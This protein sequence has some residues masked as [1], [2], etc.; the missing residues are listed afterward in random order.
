MITITQENIENLITNIETSTPNLTP[1][2]Q[3]YDWVKVDEPHR[4]EAY[5]QGHVTYVDDNHIGLKI[6]SR[7]DS[8]FDLRFSTVATKYIS[9]IWRKVDV[10]KYDSFEFQGKVVKVTSIETEWRQVK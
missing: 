5:S 2:V 10:V 4:T 1:Q 3:P 8:F 9:E 6:G 7:N